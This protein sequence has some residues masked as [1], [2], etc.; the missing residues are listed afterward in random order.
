ML[1]LSIVLT[2]R[3]YRYRHLNR[4]DRIAAI[5]RGVSC[6]ASGSKPLEVSDTDTD[7]GDRPTT[8]VYRYRYVTSRRCHVARVSL[9]LV[10]FR[11]VL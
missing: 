1:M 10:V 11:V 8:A 4:G 2:L 9:C 6:A 7:R 5:G 3:T